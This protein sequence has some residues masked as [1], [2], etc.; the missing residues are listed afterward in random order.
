[1][2]GERVWQT[3]AQLKREAADM[4]KMRCAY[5]P[6]KGI[7]PL[8]LVLFFQF[9]CESAAL[10]LS[11]SLCL[12]L[13]LPLSS[14]SFLSLHYTTIF[15]L[16]FSTSSEAFRSSNS[17]CDQGNTSILPTLLPADSPPSSLSC[18]LNLAISAS[19]HR[20]IGRTRPE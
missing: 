12:S 11:V 8:W 5:A 9:L 19:T 4:I 17:V 14:E 1:M 20:A 7:A 2:Q 10:S 15:L 13:S 18:W 6:K 3:C 16:L